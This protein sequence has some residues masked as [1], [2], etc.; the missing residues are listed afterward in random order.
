M[1]QSRTSG[2]VGAPGGRLPRATRPKL[3]RTIR[4]DSV[5]WLE[6][7]SVRIRSTLVAGPGSN[8]KGSIPPGEL[9]GGYLEPQF[10][11]RR[12]RRLVLDLRG[13]VA[14]NAETQGNLDPVS[15]SR[16]GIAKILLR[17]SRVSESALR[18][19]LVPD[20]RTAIRPAWAETHPEHPEM[21]R[22]GR[23]SSRR[24]GSRGLLIA[25]LGDARLRGVSNFSARR[26]LSVSLAVRIGAI[27]E[28]V[29]CP[30]S[31]ATAKHDQRQPAG[32]WR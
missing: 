1:R 26:S 18:D 6:A 21:G 12:S 27:V 8:V 16:A 23:A 24:I 7:G 10:P 30:I 17:L 3:G 15:P 2:S 31:G 9:E 32:L 5:G 29:P 25:N 28:R 19:Q 13:L 20:F 22:E 11:A 4:N 14:T